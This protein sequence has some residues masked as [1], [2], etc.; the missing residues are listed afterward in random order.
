MP[1][2]IGDY[3]L[4][5]CLKIAVPAILISL[6]ALIGPTAYTVSKYGLKASALLLS[7]LP[8]RIAGYALLAFRQ[9]ITIIAATLTT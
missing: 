6:T 3:W 2:I 5:D 8:A 4:F 7:K 1:P 9:K